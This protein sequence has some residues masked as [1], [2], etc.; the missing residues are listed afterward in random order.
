M[1]TAACRNGPGHLGGFQLRE[2]A[3]RNRSEQGDER[4]LG[5]GLEPLDVDREP[6][7]GDAVG[8]PL[9][10]LV[11]HPI[12]D[13]TWVE[14][15]DEEDAADEDPD[16]AEHCQQPGLERLVIPRE[17]AGRP[18]PDVCPEVL[19]PGRLDES[20]ESQGHAKE[21]GDQHDLERQQQRA[22]GA[23][24]RVRRLGPADRFGALTNGI[25]SKRCQ[26]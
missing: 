26:A 24:A 13:W 17:A 2:H 8:Q 7:R 10:Q 21:R 19:D 14:E 6:E 15:E 16:Q 22:A 5:H 11:V 18:G 3:A 25:E 4:P 23:S 20:V 1:R 12:L 9:S